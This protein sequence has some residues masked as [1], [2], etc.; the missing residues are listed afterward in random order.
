MGIVCKTISLAFESGLRTVIG[1]VASG[2][3][4][5]CSREEQLSVIEKFVSG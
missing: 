1:E 3:A 5:E 2:H 4:Y